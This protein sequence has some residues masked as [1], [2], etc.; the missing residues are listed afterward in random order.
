MACPVLP[1]S[2]TRSWW[3]YLWLT[4]IVKRSVRPWGGGRRGI[5]GE[6]GGCLDLIFVVAR[7]HPCICVCASFVGLSGT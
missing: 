6:L 2:R 1:T 7:R 5:E 3:R 4:C